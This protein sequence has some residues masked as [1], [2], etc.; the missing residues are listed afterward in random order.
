[1]A[2]FHQNLLSWSRQRLSGPFL[3]LFDHPSSVPKITWIDGVVWSR[4]CSEFESKWVVAAQEI[5]FN[6]RVCIANRFRFPSNNMRD[7]RGGIL[8]HAIL[9]SERAIFVWS[10]IRHRHGVP[11]RRALIKS[12][13]SSRCGTST[14]LQLHNKLWGMWGSRTRNVASSSTPQWGWISNDAAGITEIPN[15]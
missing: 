14:Y 12:S 15:A 1:M 13:L 9:F 3:R 11:E 6:E 2:R 5:H 8:F 10:W 7:P 4:F